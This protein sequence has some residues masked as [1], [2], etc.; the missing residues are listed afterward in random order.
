MFI[1]AD[2]AGLPGTFIKPNKLDFQP[3]LGVAWRP[4]SRTVVR[5][6]FGIYAVD[7]THNVFADQYNQPPF[8]YR[9]QL[10]RSLLLSQNVNVNSLYTFQN[11]TANGS[12]ANVAATLA[13]VGGF[14]DAYPT[15]KAYTGNVTR[16]AR[17]RPWHVRPRQLRHELH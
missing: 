1:T 14:S 16:G 4:T 11:P 13:G 2:K 5:G 8:T 9:A 10:S 15:Q 17:G 6:G 7:I 3:R 12:T